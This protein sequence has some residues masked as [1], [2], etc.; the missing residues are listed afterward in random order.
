MK[1]TVR[2][3]L[4]LGLGAG[5]ARSVQ[6]LLLTPQTG[7][8]Q[9]VREWSIEM[10]GFDDAARF[11][12]GFGNAAQLVSQLKPEAELVIK[13]A[14]VV[15]TIDRNGVIGKPAGEAPPG[16]YRR[17]T[18][19]TKAIGAIT[20]KFRT[21]PR[22]VPDRIPLLHALMARVGEVVGGAE[23]SQS[24]TQG[25]GAQSQSQGEAK[26]ERPEA[27]QFAH[28]F[29]GAARAL[30]IPARYVTGYVLASEDEPAMFHAWAEAWDDGLGWIGFDPT[31]GYCPTDSHVRVAIGLD[32][33]G[34]VPVRSVPAVGTP[35]VLAMSIEAAQ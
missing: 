32:A 27:S 25:D 28:A 19:L 23:A 2:H 16:L 9:I 7:T 26:A 17:P 4:S 20:S 21:A 35:Q 1:I 3:Q 22:G 14:G 6:H 33:L 29:I 34:T 31:L 11:I 18:P 13:V 12:D 24:Q 5:V 8:T 10:P 30:E 15:D